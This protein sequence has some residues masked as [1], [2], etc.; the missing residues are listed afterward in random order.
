V[1]AVLAALQDKFK[2]YRQSN[3]GQLHNPFPILQYRCSSQCNI[4]SIPSLA[5]V[6]SYS[7][8]PLPSAPHLSLRTSRATKGMSCSLSICAMICPTRP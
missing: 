6:W 5:Q 7:P 8:H 2:H 3:T 1:Q 4:T